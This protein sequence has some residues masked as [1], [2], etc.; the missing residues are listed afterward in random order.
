MIILGLVL[1]LLG[2]LLGFSILWLLGLVLLAGGII[3]MLL[4]TAG[5]FMVAGRRHW[6]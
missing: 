4:A 6:F 1:I 2:W 3:L 5:G